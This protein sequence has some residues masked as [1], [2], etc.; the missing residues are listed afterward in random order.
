MSPTIKPDPDQ[1][2][3]LDALPKGPLR[4]V[5]GAGTGKTSTLQAAVEALLKRPAR[6]YPIDHLL[7]L[8]FNEGAA[9]HLSRKIVEVAG[10]EIASS[11]TPEEPWI[12]TFHAFARRLLA[13][14]GARLGLAPDLELYDD[15][16]QKR[17]FGRIIEAYLAGKIP[18]E[19]APT[20]ERVKPFEGAARDFVSRLLDELVTP[21]QFL[22]IAEEKLR[23]DRNVGASEREESRAWIRLLHALYVA[24]RKDLDDSNRLDYGSLLVRTFLALRA[25]PTVLERYR[26]KFRFIFVDEFQDT[27]AAQLEILRLL[28]PRFENVLVV[29][30]K[31]QSIYEWRGARPE[32]F[33]EIGD[34]SAEIPLTR[35]Y[36][37]V[38]EILEVSDAIIAR[39]PEFATLPSLRAEGRGAANE[40]RVFL[41]EHET[42]EAEFVAR[43][44]RRL[45]GSGSYRRNEVVLL[46][47]SV[48]SASKPYEDAFR[49]L[50]IPYRTVGASGF[51]DRQEVG[52]VLAYLRVIHDPYDDTSLWRVLQNAPV[53]LDDDA[54][55]RLRQ[56]AR[57]LGV[58]LFDALAGMSEPA[59]KS[60][61]ATLRDLIT[62]Q[63]RF[64][65]SELLFHTLDRSGYR[66][67]VMSG[68]D[69]AP[70]RLGNL[71]KLYEIARNFE[72]RDVFHSLGDFLAIV[73]F[74]LESEHPEAE[75]ALSEDE[76]AVRIL[77]IH[78]AKGREFPV[79]FVGRL[80][81]PTFPTNVR[82]PEFVFDREYGFARRDVKPYDTL[83][84]P[85]IRQ[86]HARE[87]RRLL[88]VAMTRAKDRLYL[89]RSKNRGSTDFFAE[90]QALAVEMPHAIRVISATEAF[91]F[92]LPAATPLPAVTIEPHEIIAQTQEALARSG[93]AAPIRERADVDIPLSFTALSTFL[94]C[95]LEYAQAYVLGVPPA[96]VDEELEARGAAALG[97]LVH[98]T[99]RAWNESGRAVDLDRTL[100]IRAAATAAPEALVEQARSILAR[101]REDPGPPGTTYEREFTLRVEVPGAMVRVRGFID[102]LHLSDGRCRVVDWKTNR[103]F[104]PEKYELQMK[105]Y[106]AACL[107]LFAERGVTEVDTELRFLR[108]G[109]RRPATYRR[110]DLGETLDVVRRAAAAIVERRFAPPPREIRDCKF[111]RFGGPLGACPENLARAGAPAT[112]AFPDEPAAYHRRFYE[113]LTEEQAAQLRGRDSARAL[114]VEKRVEAGR[115]IANLRLEGAG[116][117][118]LTS[119]ERQ[120]RFACDNSSRFRE[121]D[122]VRLHRGNFDDD[123]FAV[124]Q[125]EKIGPTEVIIR[126]RE[127]SDPGTVTV[128]DEESSNTVIDVMKDALLGVLREPESPRTQIILGTREPSFASIV[129]T[130]RLGDPHQDL[131]IARALAARDFALVHG[132]AGTGKTTVIATL[133]RDLVRGGARV[134]LSAYTN[135]AVDHALGKVRESGV[136]G[137]IRV[138]RP[139][140][141]APEL[142]GVLLDESVSPRGRERLLDG[143]RVVAVTAA[144]A[145]RALVRNA[146][147]FDVAI[148]D[149]ASQMPEPLALAPIARADRFVL[150]GDHLQLSAVLESAEAERGGLALSLFERLIESAPIASTML[151]RQYRMNARIA[152]F[153]SREFYG[154]KLVAGNA[155]VAAL[156]LEP[157]DDSW[158]RSRLAPALDPDRPFA[159]VDC[160]DEVSIA[161][162]LVDGLLAMGVAPAQI[163]VIAP[164]RAQVVA[165]R[166]A[167]PPDVLA[168]TVDRFQGSDREAVIL[169]TGTTSG[170][171]P[172]LLRSP[173]RLNVALTRAKRKLIV[174]GDATLTG[175]AR[176]ERLVRHARDE[177]AIVTTA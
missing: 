27:N 151:Q 81:A 152:E 49:A 122:L 169:S 59:A 7:A 55:H 13:E 136:S 23:D 106:A 3:V 65:P 177:G 149:E 99:I 46:L 57:R 130:T 80:Q 107:D 129:E 67:Y 174:L 22:S 98:D 162:V 28:S 158:K 139:T 94:R 131:A 153:P 105:L 60:V 172:D 120:F 83:F 14:C 64:T 147:H 89:T 77:T 56:R 170:E 43:E 72:D 138:G 6:D 19:S 48:Q 113:L 156:R 42:R 8:T 121:G 39:D 155:T 104:E 175:D 2:R 62:D 93:V 90:A 26:E 173:N 117:Q 29:G 132:P 52:D 154:G 63:S 37:S 51:Y 34:E 141:V 84:E 150:V 157:R 17:A 161:R 32:N 61:H 30:D 133:V 126:V 142:A 134:L 148:I 128:I 15:L 146:G 97:T 102:E 35:N 82:R 4:V 140:V 166:H 123:R 47:R 101:Y 79:V 171:I 11:Q 103:R 85:A 86:N 111:C 66:K 71:K 25:F 21:E 119:G 124:G 76:D 1:Q 69:D 176:Y 33:D 96:P 135:R 165:L 36:R 144:S 167:L 108:V 70:R 12:Q 78:Q 18:V 40:P 5:A 109:E 159:F 9:E 164:Y 91:D 127:R 68:I 143:A 50:S 163:G 115:A 110:A 41:F 92:T 74:A 145:S 88:Y 24:Y 160:G 53:A 112:K 87:E 10:A 116:P 75:A 125:I 73:D 16:E 168:D 20:I 100:E 114:P 44:I 118:I 95:P 54:L 45:V 38:G 137:L 58:P 31:R